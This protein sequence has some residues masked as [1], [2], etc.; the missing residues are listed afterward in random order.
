ML[1]SVTAS[2]PT[3]VMLWSSI[4]SKW[5]PTDQGFH[6]NYYLPPLVAPWRQ[7]LFWLLFACWS[8]CLWTG[9][10]RKLWVDF[11]RNRY[12]VDQRSVN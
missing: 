2:D 6:S 11:H 12:T 4:G 5:Q 7:V 8:I 1:T 3:K 9:Q 10:L